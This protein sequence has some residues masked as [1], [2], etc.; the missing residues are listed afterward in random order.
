MESEKGFVIR[1]DEKMIRCD[2]G[3]GL[4][5]YWAHHHPDGC[6]VCGVERVLHGVH[7]AFVD[8]ARRL[9]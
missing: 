7:S 6:P 1:K 8:L 3:H 9:K 4:I 5:Y 2:K